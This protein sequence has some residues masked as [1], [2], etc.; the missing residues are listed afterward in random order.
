MTAE[1]AAYI[2][3]NGGGKTQELS[4]TKNG[5]YEPPKGVIG[6]SKVDV[7]VPDRYDDGKKEGAIRATADF[8]GRVKSKTITENGTY[9][10]SKETIEIGGQIEQLRAY[11]PVIVNV[12]DR[13]DEGYKA[14]RD[15]GYAD[16]YNKGLED[17][18]GSVD[19]SNIDFD[20]ANSVSTIVDYGDTADTYFRIDTVVKADG[21]KQVRLVMINKKT[22]ETEVT[23]TSMIILGDK[24]VWKIN[25]ITLNGNPKSGV[26]VRAIPYAN[27]E[28]KSQYGARLTGTAQSVGGTCLSTGGSPNITVTKLAEG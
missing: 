25:S 27:G 11:N 20:F 13:Y 28:S 14:G 26:E 16:G 15:D 5:T 4:V 2:M 7:N 12:P 3:M 1:E 22:G 9:Y 6:Y 24:I 8:Y 21:G 23:G 19:L 18:K 17:G 10:A